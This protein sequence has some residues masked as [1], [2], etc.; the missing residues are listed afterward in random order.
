LITVT[1]PWKYLRTKELASSSHA[2]ARPLSPVDPGPVPVGVT[3]PKQRS[4]NV[5]RSVDLFINSARPI[6]ELAGQ[7]SQLTR[8]TLKPAAE[9]GTWWLEEGDLRAELRVHPF[10]RD[11]ELAFDRYRYALSARVPDASRPADSAAAALLRVVSETLR[12]AGTASLLVH[13][14]QYADGDARTPGASGGAELPASPEVSG[15]EAGA[16]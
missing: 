7:L 14:L 13:D 10:V 6:D 8:M 12:K 11:G 3:H 4:S 2:S 15:P 9:T 5:S 16:S 1:P